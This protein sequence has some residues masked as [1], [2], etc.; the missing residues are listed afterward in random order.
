MTTIAGTDLCPNQPKPSLFLD[1]KTAA[2]VFKIS[3]SKLEKDRKARRGIPFLKVGGSVF[4]LNP[5][6]FGELARGNIPETPVR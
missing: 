4:Y 3:E 1:P 6:V 5:E 2:H